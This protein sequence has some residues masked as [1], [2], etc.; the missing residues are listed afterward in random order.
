VGKQ[1]A[2]TKKGD[3]DLKGFAEPVPVY[4]VAGQGG[5]TAPEAAGQDEPA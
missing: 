1:Y 5:V 2:I 4:L 3:F